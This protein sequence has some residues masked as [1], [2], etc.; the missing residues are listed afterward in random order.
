M[1]ITDVQEE[2]VDLAKLSRNFIAEIM[3]A[4]LLASPDQI[5]LQQHAQLLGLLID[6]TLK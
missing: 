1:V 3:G 4:G 5:E 6:A 2:L